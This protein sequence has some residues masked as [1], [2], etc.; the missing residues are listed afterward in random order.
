MY[1]YNSISASYFYPCRYRYLVKGL[2]IPNDSVPVTL[3]VGP[4]IFLTGSVTGRMACIFA[5]YRNVFDGVVRCE[6]T[7]SL[8]ILSGCGSAKLTVGNFRIRTNLSTQTETD[9]SR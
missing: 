5:R 9:M 4:L 2:L 1:E 6:Q 3:T 8:F 7:F